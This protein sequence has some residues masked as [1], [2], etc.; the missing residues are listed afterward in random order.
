MKRALILFFTICFISQSAEAQLWKMNKYELSAGFGPTFFFGD[1]GGFSN[2]ENSLGFKDLT[3][4]QTRANADLS[5]KYRISQ[6]I[7]A[8]LSL[9]G[10]FLKATD[11][12][13]SNNWR[14]FNAAITYFSP[15]LLGEYYFFKNRL[16]NNYRFHR[17]GE[18]RGAITFFRS[19]DMYAF[20]GIGG[21][22]Y[23]VKGNDELENNPRGFNSGGFTAV[24]PIGLGA[25]YVYS[26]SVDFGVEI[27]GRYALS[28]GIDG[29]TSQFSKHNDV[30]Y[31][32]NFV[33]IYKFNT[34]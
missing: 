27:S 15:T 30:Y 24:I 29:Y 33:V 3:S 14:H 28:D 18:I 11:R 9:S 2:G 4:L 16:E 6:D 10:G 5:F 17:T 1:V 26:P 19:L 12:R 22:L 21:M 25:K 32:L 8:R 31:S 13:G 34:K 20:T 23:S 7:S